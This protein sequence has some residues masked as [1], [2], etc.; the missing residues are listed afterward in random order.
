MNKKI[1]I[2]FLYLWWNI[3]RIIL[4]SSLS[5]KPTFSMWYKIS[6]SFP[7]HLIHILADCSFVDPATN[8]YKM[9]K[10]PGGW[11]SG[12]MNEMTLLSLTIFTWCKRLFFYEFN[13]EQ[14]LHQ[15][16]KQS[17]IFAWRVIFYIVVNTFPQP[18]AIYLNMYIW[19]K[20]KTTKII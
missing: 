13:F 18:V 4:P 6:T 19:N 20:I 16:Y 11:M 1:L 8:F 5:H 12:T 15:Y 14:R 2:L 17:C 10:C 7:R 3:I 9:F